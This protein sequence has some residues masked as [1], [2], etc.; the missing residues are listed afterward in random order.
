MEGA[1]GILLSAGELARI[2]KE[3]MK[4]SRDLVVQVG[5]FNTQTLRHNSNLAS[6]CSQQKK[7]RGT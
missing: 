6:R 1:V 5:M 4:P 2:G 3:G 7:L